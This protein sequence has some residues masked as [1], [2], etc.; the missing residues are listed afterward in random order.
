MKVLFYLLP[1]LAAAAPLTK[2]TRDVEEAGQGLV[3]SQE[4]ELNTTPQSQADWQPSPGAAVQFQTN[5][6]DTFDPAKRNDIGVKERSS[7][8][9]G[10]EGLNYHAEDSVTH[11]DGGTIKNPGQN[12]NP[13]D[14]PKEEPKNVK[15][16]ATSLW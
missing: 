10:N 16:V 1:A 9:P 2:V 6:D 15:Q 13:N 5:T 11:Q 4:F 3:N 14:K 12:P 8:F 7:I